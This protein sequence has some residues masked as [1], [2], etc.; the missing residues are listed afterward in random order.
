M[1]VMMTPRETWT[2]Q[3]LDDLNKKVDDGFE[4]LDGDMRE[5]RGDMKDLRGEMNELKREINERFESLKHT[6]IGAAAVIAAALIGTS[7]F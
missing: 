5:L 6:L 1:A 7:A 3:R 4:R 2:D